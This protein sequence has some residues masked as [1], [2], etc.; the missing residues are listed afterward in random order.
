MCPTDS[1][2]LSGCWEWGFESQWFIFYKIPSKWSSILDWSSSPYCQNWLWVDVDFYS[3]LLLFSLAALQILKKHRACSTRIILTE[4]TSGFT[5]NRCMKCGST[6]IHSESQCSVRCNDSLLLARWEGMTVS[7]GSIS[8]LAVN[9]R[10][11]EAAECHS[12]CNSFFLLIKIH[13]L[14]LFCMCLFI[15][16]E[17][18]HQLKIRSITIPRTGMIIMFYK[19]H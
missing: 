1:S 8:V 10:C 18:L 11:D 4:H 15:F 19:L 13:C 2:T 14:S 12:F 6:L 9:N 5:Q 17:S 7:K 16:F 3:F